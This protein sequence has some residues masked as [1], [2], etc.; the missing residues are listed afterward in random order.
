MAKYGQSLLYQSDTNFAPPYKLWEW[1]RFVW[2]LNCIIDCPTTSVGPVTNS[3]LNFDRMRTFSTRFSPL[4]TYLGCNPEGRVW[5]L[6]I[7]CRAY[8]IG[9]MLLMLVYASHRYGQG[10]NTIEYWQ[11]Y[12]PPSPLPHSLKLLL[13]ATGLLKEGS[14]LSIFLMVHCSKEKYTR[15]PEKGK[16]FTDRNESDGSQSSLVFPGGK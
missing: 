8:L 3:P 2:A 7:L 11:Y 5:V 4:V 13:A 9:A 16:C 10:G 6:I 12:S 1:S 15:I 14:S